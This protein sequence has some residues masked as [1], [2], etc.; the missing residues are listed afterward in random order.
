[1]EADEEPPDPEVS[2]GPDVLDVMPGAALAVDEIIEEGLS[3]G[4]EPG[5]V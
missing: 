1:M 5:T 3:G 4:D 2:E